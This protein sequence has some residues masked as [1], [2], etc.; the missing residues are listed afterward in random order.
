VRSPRSRRNQSFTPCGDAVTGLRYDDLEPR[1][2]L[3]GLTQWFT[4][5]SRWVLA[6]GAA[7][8]HRL[9]TLVLRLFSLHT[10]YKNFSTDP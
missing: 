4:R 9:E 6:T 7:S 3:H 5:R 1:L 8:I 10:R 2:I